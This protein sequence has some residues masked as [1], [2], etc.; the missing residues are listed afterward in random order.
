M[1]E[2]VAEGLDLLHAGDLHN[3]LEIAIR[4]HRF[5]RVG[6]LISANGFDINHKH[7]N[8]QTAL[9]FAIHAESLQ[10]CELLLCNNADPNVKDMTGHSPLHYAQDLEHLSTCFMMLLLSYRADVEF[11]YPCDDGAH[12]TTP[13]IR[14]VMGGRP[15]TDGCGRVLISPNKP[16]Q[17]DKGHVIVPDT[18]QVILLLKYA[19]SCISCNIHGATAL[20]IAARANNC[21][22]VKRLWDAGSNIEARNEL[23][24]TP[25]HNACR[26]GS[27]SIVELLLSKGADVHA[28]TN[29]GDTS[30]H[31]A[32]REGNID[33]IKL[34]IR[35]GVPDVTNNMGYS[36]AGQ[37]CD[38]YAKKV[39]KEELR[40]RFV[41]YTNP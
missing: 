3:K 32:V 37:K 27:A 19:A 41:R 39:A 1:D 12:R 20:H 23:G 36:A 15:G 9:F 2:H 33:T 10:I 28:I 14:A 34:L 26:D 6:E 38:P 18:E 22:V 31:Q 21:T 30:L 5:E 16:N 40:E 24:A 29:N 11:Q 4:N 17:D 8:G 7:E 35:A 13:L 25:L